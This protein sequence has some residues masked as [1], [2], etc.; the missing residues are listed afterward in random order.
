MTLPPER[1]AIIYDYLSKAFPGAA[2]GANLID[3]LSAVMLGGANLDIDTG[4]LPETLWPGSNLYP[5]PTVA[6][7]ATVVSS[8]PLDT[9]LGTGARTV[10]LVGVDDEYNKVTEIVPLDG[11]DPVSTTRTDWWRINSAIVLTNGAHAFGTNVGTITV[12][13]GAPVC[14]IEPRRG[15][16]RQGTYTVPNDQNAIWMS[17]CIQMLRAGGA[18]EMEVAVYARAENG[19]WFAASSMS[20]QTTGTSGLVCPSQLPTPLPPKSDIE[21]RIIHTDSVNIRATMEMTILLV[22]TAA[23]GEVQTQF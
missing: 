12:S 19:P 8:D 20:T 4:S 7:T 1:A 9:A 3:G 17:G 2:I 15:L 5:W 11:T 21:V 13:N 23:I 22:E 18:S 10:L 6:F 16:A 14:I